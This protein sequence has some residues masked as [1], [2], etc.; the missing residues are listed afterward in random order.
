MENIVPNNNYSLYNNSNSLFNSYY[1]SSYNNF[2]LLFNPYHNST[3]FESYGSLH[4]TFSSPLTLDGLYDSSRDSSPF[5][6][7]PQRENEM[8]DNIVRLEDDHQK[9]YDNNGEHEVEDIIQLD[10]YQEEE[11]DDN[12]HEEEENE[13]RFDQGM[14]FET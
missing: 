10:D 14:E 5:L 2:E 12:E 13:I 8:I 3:T 7:T 9:E 4:N 1:D 11:Y 6:E